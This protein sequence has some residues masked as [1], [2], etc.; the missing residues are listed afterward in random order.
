MESGTF[1]I[2]ERRQ[3]TYGRKKKLAYRAMMRELG[4]GNAGAQKS[5]NRLLSQ[6]LIPSSSADSIIN[7]NARCYSGQFSD[8]GN[9]FFSCAQDF[10]VRMYDTSNPYRWKYYKTAHY[11]GGQ[12]TITDATLSPDNRFLAYSSI[13]SAVCLSP[14]D[15]ENTMEPSVLEFSDMG[16]GRR[17]GRNWGHFGVCMG[18][19]YRSCLILT[20]CRSGHF[21]TQAMDE[22]LLLALRT[23]VSMYMTLKHDS[24]SSEFTGTPTTSMPCATGTSPPL[25]SYTLA[26]TIRRSKFG[27]GAPWVMD[28]RPARL[29][30][31]LKVLR[32]SIAKAMEGMCSATPRT[33]P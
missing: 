32:T 4:L 26:P 22:R 25:T 33:R 8:D 24:Q 15:P 14:T 17:G 12:W 6:T 7:Y 21:D 16:Q 11:L 13:R 27:I 3:G 19:P 9:F 31:T 28:V 23:R 20:S 10:R 5:A 18:P 30:G 2:N 29:L 1:G